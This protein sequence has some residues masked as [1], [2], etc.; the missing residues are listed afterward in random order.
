ME[1][2]NRLL[3]NYFTQA[4]VGEGLVPSQRETTRVSPTK[5]NILIFNK[6]AH[7][8]WVRFGIAWTFSAA[9]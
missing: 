4:N 8:L 1:R 9:C 7:P 2:T 6:V 3:K 5:D